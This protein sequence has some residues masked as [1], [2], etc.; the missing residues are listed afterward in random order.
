MP[1]MAEVHDLQD[2]AMGTSDPALT[3]HLVMQCGLRPGA[4][5]Q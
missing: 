3:T 4:A 1:A 5:C 2:W